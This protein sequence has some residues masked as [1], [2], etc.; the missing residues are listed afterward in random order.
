MEDMPII[1]PPGGL[2]LESW[3]A[4]AWI[5]LYAPVRLVVSV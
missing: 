2:C 1:E 4:A 3:V 5:V